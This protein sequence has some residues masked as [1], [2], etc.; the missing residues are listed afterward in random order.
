VSQWFVYQG[1]GSHVGPVSTDLLVRGI[2]AG[3]VPQD[4]HVAMAGSTE[5]KPLMTVSEL[6]IALEAL[7]E[8]APPASLAL[9]PIPASPPPPPE[10]PASEADATEVHRR[11]EAMKI[12]LA[13][14]R[15]AA[16][17]P[18]KPP[19]RSNHPPPLRPSGSMAIAPSKSAIPAAAPV[20][21]APAVPAAAPPVVPP[22]PN[23]VKTLHTEPLPQPP[24]FAPPAQSPS[25]APPPFVAAVAAKEEPKKPV[26]D[27]KLT[28]LL[29]L[30]IFGVFVVLSL[31][32][33]VY[34]LVFTRP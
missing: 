17:S 25:N 16:V 20:D 19:A 14:A 33:V 1:E 24:S 4:A 3:R 27:P 6:V 5:W 11:D 13:K 23:T 21:K 7:D 8:D 2:A 12:M 18:P 9:D 10:P 32:V 22:P 29:P 28:L 26:V 15:P 30:G 31:F 34:A